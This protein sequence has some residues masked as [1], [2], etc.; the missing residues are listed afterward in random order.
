MYAYAISSLPVPLLPYSSP[1]LAF[2]FSDLTSALPTDSFFIFFLAALAVLS[3]ASSS[4]AA[5]VVSARERFFVI[6][7][8][9]LVGLVVPATPAPAPISLPAYF[10]WMPT[11]A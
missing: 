9:I 3:S 10:F 2:S 8:W 7:P 4:L 11:N 1:A 6:L 5:A